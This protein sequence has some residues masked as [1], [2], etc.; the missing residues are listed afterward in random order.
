MGLFDNLSKTLTQGVDRA[1]FEADKFQKTTRLQSELNEL[2]DGKPGHWT[3]ALTSPGTFGHFGGSGTFLWVD[4]ERELALVC[5]T[6]REYGPWALDAWPHFSD[7][8]IEA[9]LG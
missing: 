7:D 4:P 9:L 1:K 6:D 5:L 3:G 8:V 2:K